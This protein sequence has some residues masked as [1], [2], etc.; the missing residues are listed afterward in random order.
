MIYHGVRCGAPEFFFGLLNAFL[1]KKHAPNRR[2]AERQAGPLLARGAPWAWAGLKPSQPAQRSSTPG[3][4]PA[5]SSSAASQLPS[6]RRPGALPPTGAES[7]GCLRNARHCLR[8]DSG[9]L[10]CA[11]RVQGMKR[12]QLRGQPGCRMPTFD[13]AAAILTWRLQRIPACFLF[14]PL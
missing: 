4:S 12:G 10:V 1:S 6:E 14:A 3:S 11:Q 13:R 9:R 5:R 7:S 8:T 2:T